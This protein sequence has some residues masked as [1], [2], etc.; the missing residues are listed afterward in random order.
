MR[1]NRAAKVR[2]FSDLAGFLDV[3]IM[4][5]KPAGTAVLL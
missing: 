1:S 4:S 5:P 3:S 2:N